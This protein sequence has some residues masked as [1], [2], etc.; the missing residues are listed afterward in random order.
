M[1][2]ASV[3]NID[4]EKMGAMGI[5]L[6]IDDGVYVC[7]CTVYCSIFKE[8]KQH[9]FFY[10]SHFSTKENSEYYGAISDNISYAPICVLEGKD[11]EIKHTLK[12]MLR[13]F[14]EGKCTVDFH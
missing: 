7:I 2:I 10:D 13:N 6:V 1:T 3:L 5:L 11:I 14:F 8:V 12:N 4:R 9:T